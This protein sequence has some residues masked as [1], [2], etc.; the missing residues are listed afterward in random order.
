M[1]L[2]AIS[3]LEELVIRVHKL[4]HD[5]S[6]VYLALMKRLSKGRLKMAGVGTKTRE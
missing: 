2:G 6:E 3:E 4:L 5:K 1:E